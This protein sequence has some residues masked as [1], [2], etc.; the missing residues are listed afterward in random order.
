MLAEFVQSGAISFFE[1]H[2]LNRLT[3][4]DIAGY[5][6]QHPRLKITNIAPNGKKNLY[7]QDPTSLFPL[8][9]LPVK[10]PC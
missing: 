9:D 7:D 3:K 10:G 4:G 2:M 5:V 8:K 6:S 1:I